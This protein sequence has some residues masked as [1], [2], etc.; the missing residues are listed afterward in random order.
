MPTAALK[1]H[2]APEGLPAGLK[3]SSLVR[4]KTLARLLAPLYRSLGISADG[5]DLMETAGGIHLRNSA[6]ASP[7]T[8]PF[9]L[10]AGAGSDESHVQLTI[11]PGTVSGIMPTLG[12]IDLDDGTP[13]SIDLSTS[14]TFKIYLEINAT[15]TATTE[16]YVVAWTIDSVTVE[17]ASTIPADDPTGIYRRHIGTLVDGIIT[18]QPVQNSLEATLIDNGTASEQ[19]IIALGLSG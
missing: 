10:V 17:Y 15:L 18:A 4:H 8:F 7:A 12:G 1:K 2:P 11:L 13:P 5:F 16:G 6:I 14:G 9:K 19:A 3:G